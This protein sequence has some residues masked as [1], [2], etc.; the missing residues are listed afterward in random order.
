MCIRDSGAGGLERRRWPA[1][2]ARGQRDLGFGHHAAGARHRILGAER[3]G[4]AAHQR[5][6]AFEVAQLRQRDAA[7]RQRRRVVAQRHPAQRGQG[8]AAEMCIRDRVRACWLSAASFSL[9]SSWRTC[10][11]VQAL[12][13]IHI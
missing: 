6:G 5:P 12:S 9:V 11:S 3:A 4:G 1:Q 13:L 2:V 8:I 10:A 7:Q